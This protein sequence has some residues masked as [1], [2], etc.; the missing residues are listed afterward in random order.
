[1]KHLYLIIAST[2]FIGFMTGVYVFIVIGKPE[3]QISVLDNTS[4]GI[5]II[6]YEYG[7]CEMLGCSSY[8]ILEDG[9][10]TFI[11]NK[12]DGNVEKYTDNLSDNLINEMIDSIDKS[13][14]E[15]V[16]NSTFEGPCPAD[17]DGIG[18][19]FKILMDN[20]KYVFDSCEND[21]MGSKFL[22]N[23]IDY[24]QIFYITHVK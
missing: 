17:V 24:F 4:A 2:F 11:Q 21:I 18:Y 16:Y 8:R 12:R 19:R 1:M 20:E 10:Y 6:A 15:R 9:S 14:L 22:V 5:E 23:L 7:G 13:E 3:V